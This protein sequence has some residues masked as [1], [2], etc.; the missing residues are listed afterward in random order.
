M[1]GAIHDFEG[2]DVHGLNGGNRDNGGPSNVDNDHRDNADENLAVRLVLE[3]D[4]SC[5]FLIKNSLP[6][7]FCDKIKSITHKCY[8]LLI[9]C[10][11]K[12][13]HPTKIS[14]YIHIIQAISSDL[15]TK[16]SVGRSFY[17][18]RKLDC[19]SFGEVYGNRPVLYAME[20]IKTW[21]DF[22][23]F[24]VEGY[25]LRRLRGTDWHQLLSILD[26]KLAEHYKTDVKRP[27]IFLKLSYNAISRIV[28]NDTIIYRFKGGGLPDRLLA[29]L[30]QNHDFLSRSKLCNCVGAERGDSI[31]DAIKTI[32]T[33]LRKKLYLPPD[34]PFIERREGFGY[35]INP[36][37]YEIAVIQ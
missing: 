4:I 35:H 25:E 14:D 24:P 10:M 37:W 30:S 33:I 22:A 36:E 2:A 11:S 6:I 20:I 13:E 9:R 27:P 5:E 18:R 29:F 23:Q 8:G 17:S 7:L 26:A 31:T 1:G 12:L 32:N 16:L 19:L 15:K 34:K 3:C 28:E 21:V